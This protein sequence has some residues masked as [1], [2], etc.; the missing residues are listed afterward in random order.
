MIYGVNLSCVINCVKRNC[1]TRFI[2]T[3]S[4]MR[5]R[6]GTSLTSKKGHRN[7]LGFSKIFSEQWLTFLVQKKGLPLWHS[8]GLPPKPVLR[9]AILSMILPG[10]SVKIAWSWQ[11]YWIIW[12]TFTL[13]GKNLG[14]RGLSCMMSFFL[15]LSSNGIGITIMNSSVGKGAGEI[16]LLS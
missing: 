5:S 15:V 16:F 7:S 4:S 3:G 1:G 8:I 6:N 10:S 11:E 13:S 2:M 12:R 9:R 14:A